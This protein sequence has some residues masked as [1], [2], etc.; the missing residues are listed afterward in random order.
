MTIAGGSY[1]H[2]IFYSY[3]WAKQQTGSDAL[4]DWTRT[5]INHL[6]TLLKIRFN[7]PDEQLSVFLD[8]ECLKN[9]ARLDDSLEQAVRSSAVFVAV[10]S[11]FYQNSYASRELEWFLDQ[12]A[13]DGSSLER[14]LHLLVIQNVPDDGW[15]RGLKDRSGDRLLFQTLHDADGCPLDFEQFI[16]GCPTP[17]LG[18]PSKEAALELQKKL[19]TIK[20]DNEARR[21]YDSAQRPPANSIVFFEAEAEDEPN[22]KTH[23][24]HLIGCEHI[25][26]PAS[27][28][29]PATAMTE[30][31][32]G[33]CDGMV[34]LRSRENDQIGERLRKA[35][36]G[37]RAV[38]SKG[39]MVPWVLL[40]ELDSPPPEADAYRI[41]SVVPRGDWVA[42]LQRK[43]LG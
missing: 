33:D 2:D 25:I 4:R 3:A 24:A 31:T 11:S 41:P 13:A 26:L 9:G 15:P 22:W 8:S 6:N 12:V 29:E 16:T 32:Y 30:A 23:R 20:K 18:A 39:K 36:L 38:L 34:L 1:Q 10:I 35:Y 27:A 21:A 37:R 5:Y 19:I 14:R 40:D 42:E 7:K 17:L 28:P 43:L